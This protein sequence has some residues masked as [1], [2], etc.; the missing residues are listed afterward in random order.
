MDILSVQEEGRWWGISYYQPPCLTFLPKRPANIFWNFLVRE[1]I[2]IVIGIWSAENKRSTVVISRWGSVAILRS[3]LWISLLCSCS[4]SKQAQ[5]GQKICSISKTR[6][7]RMPTTVNLANTN[8][9]RC[10]NGSSSNLT[11]AV[12][13]RWW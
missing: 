5:R 10:R 6:A 13:P 3:V 9:Y 11:V 12:Q 7:I 8:R 1:A 4:I 2:I